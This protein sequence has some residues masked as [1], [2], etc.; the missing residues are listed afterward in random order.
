MRFL[1]RKE[2]SWGWESQGIGIEGEFQ[3][4]EEFST[5]KR[6]L[7]RDRDLELTRIHA[8][9]VMSLRMN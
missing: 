8:N 4:T 1:T 9:P 2:G 7:A 3:G 5:L 6:L